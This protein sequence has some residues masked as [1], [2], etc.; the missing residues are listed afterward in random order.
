MD[1][2]QRPEDI[3]AFFVGAWNE[4]DASRLASMF[5]EDAEF[6]NVVGLWWHDRASIERAHTY[7][8]ERIFPDSTL[9]LIRTTVRMLGHDTAVVHA[10]MRLTDQSS[11]RDVATPGIRQN[12]FSF[13]ARRT[14]AGW[15]CVSAHNTDVVPG[16]ETNIIDSDGRMRSVSYR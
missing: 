11:S 4:H 3:P 10:K 13:V 2:P 8:F 12:I 15:E 16:A 1:L 5:A 14:K 7:G 9:R 6:V